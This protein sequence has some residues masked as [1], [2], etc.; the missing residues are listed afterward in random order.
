MRD[1]STRR[2]ARLAALVAL[3][4]ALVAGLLAYRLM[5]RAGVDPP[6]SA[7]PAGSRS[8]APSSGGSTEPVEVTAPPLAAPAAQTCRALLAKLPDHLGNLRR[9]PVSAGPEQNAA[10]GDPPL[11]VACG[12]RGPVVPPGAQYLE[13]NGICWYANPGSDA[14]VWSLVGRDVS[15]TVTMPAAYTGENLVDLAAPIAQ[16]LPATTPATT[17]ACG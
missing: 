8:P 14:A 3:P 11:L 15:L 6:G 2:A 17:S 9:R 4:V 12:A 10:Y 13:V 5:D 1:P 7:A 16:T